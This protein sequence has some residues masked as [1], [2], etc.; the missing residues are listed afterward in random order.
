MTKKIFKE[1]E[2]LELSKN[3]YVKNVTSKG[4][5]YTNEFKLQF[6][7][8]YKDGKNSRK[9]FEDAGF[10]IEMIGVKRIDSASL[11]WRNAYKDK[12][13]LGLDDTR[14]LNS[15]RTLNRELTIEEVLAKKDAEI[16]YLKAELELIKKLE[17]QERQVIN[18]KLSP[19]KI[20]KIIQNLIKDFNLNKLTRYLCKI[21]NVSTSGYYKF[22]NNFKTRDM[23][24]YSDL[25]SKEIILKAFN[26]RGYKKGSRSIKMIL[27]NK[28]NI[29]MNRKKIQRIMRKYNIICPIRKA[30]PYKRIA[31]ATKAHRVVPNKLNRAFKQ[32][33]PGKIMLTD[34]TYMPYGNNKMAYLSTIKDS[35]TNEILAYKLSNSLDIDIVIET[36]DKL[37]KLKPFRLH[38]DAFVHSDKGFHYTSPIFQRLLKENNLGQSMSRRGNCWDNAPQESFF[39][40]MKDEIDYKNCNTIEELRIL[41]DDY[42]DYYNNDRCQ[43]NLKKLTPVQYRNQL[44]SA[45]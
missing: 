10:D 40:H 5:T 21:A 15:G 7:A 28:F 35:S 25:K 42:M 1:H 33:I 26:Y 31:K 43:W 3:K 4:I 38:K 13:V 9:I 27:K 34:I 24:E 29:I 22:L 30:N 41:I 6:I 32:N 45:F 18:K 36:I 2:I 12:G 17:L 23:K 19:S 37:I 11:R 16:A 8:Q 44:L 20:F 14:S 39:G